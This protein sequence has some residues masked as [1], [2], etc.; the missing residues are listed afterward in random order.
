MPGSRYLT[1]LLLTPCL[2]AGFAKV[3]PA[4]PCEPAA[5]PR[6]A[7]LAFH[8]YLVNRRNEPLQ[9]VFDGY[10]SFRNVGDAPLTITKMEPSCGCLQPQ[11]SRD[12]WTYQ[13]G[14]TGAFRVQV[15]TANEEPGPHEYTVK[16]Q[17]TD[18]D[19]Q[20]TT[21]RFKLNLPVRK[22]TVDPP[23]LAFFQYNGHPAKRDVYV[24]D[25]RGSSLE[26]TRVTSSL[27]LLTARIKP[28]ETDAAGHHRIPIELNVPGTVPPGRQMATLKIETN[29]AEFHFIRIPILIDGPRESPKTIQLINLESAT[30][31]PPAP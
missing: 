3:F 27:D 2:G 28:A 21:V 9:P 23:E 30:P 15:A 10:Y 31:G 1:L 4:S 29:D 5:G 6:R 25:F 19:P 11:I 14:E 8:Q 17:Y 26:V 12:Q 20:E 13:P 24:T 7:S 22:I 16:V 18:P